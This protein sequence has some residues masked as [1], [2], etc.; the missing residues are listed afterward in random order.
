MNN[1][2]WEGRCEDCY[3]KRDN[4]TLCCTPLIPE[5]FEVELCE[6]CI[7]IRTGIHNTR[8]ILPEIGLLETGT[9][10]DTS[11]LN[12]SVSG[13]NIIAHVKFLKN[14]E[15]AGLVRLRFDDRPQ[16]FAAGVWA[17]NE[18]YAHS[19]ARHFIRTNYFPHSP[20]EFH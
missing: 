11:P 5:G 12:F 14:S 15:N 4:L 13:E 2:I 18:S 16:W 19:E 6:E 20:V 8:G 3:N 1:R 7:R 10:Q 17:R 9:W